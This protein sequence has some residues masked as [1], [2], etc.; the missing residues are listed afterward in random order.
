MTNVKDS[1]ASINIEKKKQ[2][3]FSKLRN[4]KNGLSFKTKGLIL[5]VNQDFS[6]KYIRKILYRNKLSHT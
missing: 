2:L 1:G 6:A 5:V 4:M 3:D